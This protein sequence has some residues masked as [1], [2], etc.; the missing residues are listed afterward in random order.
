MAMS[1]KAADRHAKQLL[2]PISSPEVNKIVTNQQASYP[3]G[4]FKGGP[5]Q[6]NPRKSNNQSGRQVSCYCCSG[7]DHWGSD[8]IFRQT[9]CHNCNKKG[10]LAK[11]CRSSRPK[12][13]QRGASRHYH[14][15]EEVSQGEV[16]F[17]EAPSELPLFQ[18][19]HT[20]VKPITVT[21]QI[22][23]IALPME[24][25]TGAVM[26]VMID[27]ISAEGCIPRC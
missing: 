27:S 20:V 17:E 5:R 25:D 3:K 13:Q 19:D 6:P 15:T 21:V 10:H 1:A 11:V 26:S 16:P 8:C 7:T 24:V 12:N 14:M 4:S 9:E 18:L 23:G 2:Q 22:N